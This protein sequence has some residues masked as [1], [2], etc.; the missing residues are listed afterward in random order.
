MKVIKFKS[1]TGDELSYIPET[2]RELK[3]AFIAWGVHAW[4]VKFG[5]KYDIMYNGSKLVPTNLNSVQG[6]T[7][8]QWIEFAIKNNPNETGER[9]ILYP[10]YI[11]RVEQST[12]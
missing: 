6:M 4:P 9:G 12:I 2:T 5:G 7:L 11:Q 8:K 10:E 3:R 1:L